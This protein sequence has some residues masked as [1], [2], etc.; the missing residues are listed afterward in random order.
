MTAVLTRARA[1]L[2]ARR[3]SMIAL[4]LLVGI[5][6]ATVMTLA[7]GARRT[8]TAYP[9]FA[10][11]Y[12]AADVV[13]YP[14]FGSEF[15]ILD[16]NTVARLPQV[17][18]T[19]VQ[20]FFAARDSSLQVV[21][22]D[23]AGGVSID[24]FKILE[25]KAPNPNSLDEVMVAFDFA[26]LRHLHVG[27]RLSVT[28]G[29]TQNKDLP[30]MTLRVVGVEASPGEFPPLLGSNNFGNGWI[31]ITPA[32]ASSLT[33]QHV[34]TFKFLLVR[35]KH[36]RADYNAFN[37]EL[38]ALA[39][40]TAGGKP[41]LNQ[42]QAPQAANVQRSIHLEAVALWIV[43]ALI[44][45]I[46][47]L[48]FSQ[49]LARQ[50]ALD[51][52]E[53]PTLLALGMTRWQLWLAGMGR[54]AVIG[55]AAAAVGV[56]GG[57]FASTLMP[58]GLARNAEPSTGFS[59]DPLLLG[60]IAAGVIVMVLAVAAWPVWKSTRAIAREP[61]R[62]ER[63]SLVSRTAAAP[64]FSP[65]ASTGMRLA[66]EAGRGPTEVPVRS[67]MLS[68]VLAIVALTGALSFGSSLDHLLSTPRLYGW[69]WDVH[70]TTN[71]A[72]DNIAALKILEPD[73][74][75]A[76]IANIDTP[77]VVVNDTARLDLLGLQDVK[78]LIQ[79]VLVDGRAPETTGEIA[80]GTKTIKD[81]HVHIGSTV[82]MYISAVKA[83]RAQFKVVGTVV[84]PP[85]SDSARLGEGAVLVG[86][87][88]QRMA[89]PHFTIPQPSDLFFNF[90]PGVNKKA[91]EADL[92]GKFGDQYTLLFPQRPT[93]LVNFGQVQNLPLLLAGLVALLAAATLAHTLATSIRRRRRDFAILKMLGFVP[94]Q[95]RSTVAWQATTFVSVALL[96]G[97]PV[98]IAVGRVVWTAF[99]TQLGTVPEPA[100]PPVRLLLTI[101]GAIVLANVIAAIPAVIAGRMRPAP[102]LRAE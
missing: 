46:A 70:V 95:V 18:A 12:K 47:V 20:H 37:D 43:A 8:D 81:L 44:A 49:L 101:A 102:A 74:R 76:D 94:P 88:E 2:R 68:V 15:A 50:A 53:S 87:A 91:V 86:P 1:E 80:L 99:A 75:I 73:P 27:S 33:A 55:V 78:G 11:A 36:G 24:R 48:I 85:N 25:G 84:I 58:V 52:T 65:P 67:S 57:F 77:P 30:P 45:L 9:R 71:N 63:P 64:G 13:V 97:I 28:F 79:P 23:A 3:A 100:T 66:L 41:Q 29:V 96:I 42:S 51:A 17:E 56:L 39:T 69:N 83:I 19:S 61:A 62:S 82:T 92:R 31:H 21:G 90:A 4:T 59:F 16:F 35:L 10:R 26:R 93:D 14:S 38:N 40:A 98:G 6:A 34:F 7:A 72:M 22:S 5:G 60:L 32:L 54:M 89:P